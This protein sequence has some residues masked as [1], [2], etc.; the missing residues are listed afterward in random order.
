MKDLLWDDHR[1]EWYCSVDDFI[2]G[3]IEKESDCYFAFFYGWSNRW[4]SSHCLFEKQFK[5]LEDAK[6]WIE[7]LYYDNS[8]K[9]KFIADLFVSSGEV[10]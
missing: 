8:E 2:V 4:N 1:Y 10:F 6:D 5:D 3:E 9:K 7:T